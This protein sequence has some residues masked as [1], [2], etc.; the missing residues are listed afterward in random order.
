[1]VDQTLN[2]HNAGA[3]IKQASHWGYDKFY[4]V[5]NGVGD[6]ITVPWGASDWTTAILGT[7]LLTGSL[8]VIA[9]VGIVFY[10]IEK[11]L[12]SYS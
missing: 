5:C 7:V 10:K 11:E 6:W 4:N 12:N 1:M 2:L 3:C 9:Y 8:A